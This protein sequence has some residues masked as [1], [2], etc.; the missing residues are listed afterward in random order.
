[1]ERRSSEACLSTRLFVISY[2]ELALDEFANKGMRWSTAR[3]FRDTSRRYTG[4]YGTD[5]KMQAG[6]D[7]FF[8]STVPKVQGMHLMKTS[9]FQGEPKY[10]RRLGALSLDI[11]L[12]YQ[13]KCLLTLLKMFFCGTS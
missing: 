8:S 2:E 6:N 4:T 12:V 13:R 1:M 10:K 7:P 11:A 9:T 5:F 3:S